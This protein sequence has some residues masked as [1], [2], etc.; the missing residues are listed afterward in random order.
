V[1]ALWRGPGLVFAGEASGSSPSVAVA[2]TVAID[3]VTNKNGL[4]PIALSA[5]VTGGVAPY[6]YAWTATGPDSATGSFDDATSA[7]PTFTPDVN[8]YWVIELT[9]TDANLLT[10]SDTEDYRAGYP[11]PPVELVPAPVVS[12][13]DAAYKVRLFE[14]GTNMDNTLI[15][16]SWS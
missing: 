10:G 3:A 5:D 6:S 1:I 14:V 13:P 12:D 8:G 16:E 15:V 11:P 9:V 7:T 2:P 4:D